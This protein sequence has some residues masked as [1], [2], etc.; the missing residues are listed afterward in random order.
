MMNLTFVRSVGLAAVGAMLLALLLPVKAQAATQDY[1][2]IAYSP[3]KQVVAAGLAGSASAAAA[4][5]VRQCQVQGGA[6]D[7]WALGWFHNAVGAFARATNGAYGS[8]Q[9]WANN[10]NDATGFADR[11]AIQTCH[12][13]GGVDCRVTFR[14]RTSSVSS[15]AGG[16]YTQPSGQNWANCQGDSCTAAIDHNRT[17]AFITLVRATPKAQLAAA[18]IQL[19]SAYLLPIA[20]ACPAF[21]AEAVLLGVVVA[22]QMSQN[23]VGRGV[24][25]TFLTLQP[26]TK[27]GIT[28]Q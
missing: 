8:G 14:T 16:A 25:I 10:V 22:D 19:C 13:N 18:M 26:F 3:S 21:A 9:G 4:D 15:G 20:W 11:Y 17:Q 23:D 12:D 24:Y 27:F 2:S 5:A 28:P 7:C 6:A 1:G